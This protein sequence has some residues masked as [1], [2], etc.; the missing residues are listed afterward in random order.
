MTRSEV[1]GPPAEPVLGGRRPTG[2]SLMWSGR[3]GP[4]KRF[5][6]R[7]AASAVLPSRRPGASSG[8]RPRPGRA[9]PGALPERLVLDRHGV[10]LGRPCP[11]VG[12]RRVPLPLDR[13]PAGHLGRQLR[14]RLLEAAAEA[15]GLGL[16]RHPRQA[17]NS[18]SSVAIR[19]GWLGAAPGRRR[20]PGAAPGGDDDEEPDGQDAGAKHRGRLRVRAGGGVGR[21]GVGTSPLTSAARSRAHFTQIARTSPSPHPAGVAG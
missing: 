17:R 21:A 16:G 5:R 11:G 18:S 20:R 3:A 6:T 15:V 10:P 9:C 14:F 7:P 19:C 2:S 12:P 1:G 4:T 8:R 13:Q